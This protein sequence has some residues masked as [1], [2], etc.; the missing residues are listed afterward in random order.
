MP[1][2]S[3]PSAASQEGGRN[4]GES[5][6]RTDESNKPET[7]T[8]DSPSSTNKAPDKTESYVR[9]EVPRWLFFGL[10]V[11]VA[12]MAVAAGLYRVYVNPTWR[13]LDEETVDRLLRDIGPEGM[14]MFHRY[15]RDN[16]NYLSLEE[17][18]PLIY[19]LLEVN[20]SLHY[21]A[22]CNF[23]TFTYAKCKLWM[24]LTEIRKDFYQNVARSF[25]AL[26]F[27]ASGI[28]HQE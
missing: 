8:P 21:L 14:N 4:P 24:C 22:L 27:F 9:I 1:R 2:S 18:E 6:G 19:R 17:F 25:V 13:G 12:C 15:D 7:H 10:S 23:A 5:R 26:R 11:L 20:V 28:K 16:D 3:H